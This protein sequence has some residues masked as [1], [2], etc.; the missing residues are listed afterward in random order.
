MTNW[1]FLAAAAGVAAIV[2]GV[3]AWLNID[4]LFFAGYVVLQ[5]VV[6]ASAWN[7]LGGY[8]GYMNLGIS[9]FFALGAYTTV[10]LETAWKLPLPATIPAAAIVSGLVGLGM[11]YL[12]LRLKGIFFAIATLALAVVTETFI[13]NW[14]YV[15]G[16]AGAYLLHPKRGPWFGS[17]IEY[18]FLLMLI[19]AAFAVVV[20]RAVERSWLG[21]GFTAIRDD[22]T[23]AEATGVPTLRLKLVAT[24]LSGALMGMAGAPLPYYVSFLE[25]ASTFNLAYAVNTIAMAMIGGTTT[26]LGPLIGAVLLATV[27]QVA[28]VTISSEINLMV[29]GVLLVGFVMLAPNGIVGLLRRRSSGR[30]HLT[31][32][33]DEPTLPGQTRKPRLG[34]AG[35]V[36][37][38]RG[39]RC[40]AVTR[41]RLARFIRVRDRGPHC[42]A[43]TLVRR[44]GRALCCAAQSRQWQAQ[45]RHRRSIGR[46]A[47][48]R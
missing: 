46:R 12:T 3:A 1:R 5:Y 15:G 37:C 45:C 14:D 10:A 48:G 29:V 11:G 31:K 16:S 22:E 20:A 30:R 34:G 44:G 21:Y 39:G 19:V 9:A 27:Q 23:A 8:T 17:Y 40:H 2:F 25:P 36:A 38:R 33:V 18:L 32:T 35:H 4:Y 6:L 43:R 28:T 41:P 26:W 24:G 7:I 47:Q 13:T 42:R